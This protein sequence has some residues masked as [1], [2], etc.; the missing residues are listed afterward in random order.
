MT[1]RKSRSRAKA[2]RPTTVA[3]YLASLTPEKR[4]VTQLHDLELTS[5]ARVIGM[6]TP[7][8]YI[9]Y[10]TRVRGLA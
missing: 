6:S 5:V 1:A 7:K 8:E 4:A 3:A 9:A 10:Y 2:V